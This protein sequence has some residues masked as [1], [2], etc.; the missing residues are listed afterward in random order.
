MEI[1]VWIK[2]AFGQRQ[3]K[4]PKIESL[5]FKNPLNTTNNRRNN[6]ILCK[7]E[8]RHL[9][10]WNTADCWVVFT[11]NLTSV[12]QVLM[13]AGILKY[14]NLPWMKPYNW[15]VIEKWLL[16][17]YKN[18]NQEQIKLKT[19]LTKKQIIYINKINKTI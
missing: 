9:V 17:K 8:F 1:F 12:R 13:S 16:A 2:K 4:N 11:N 14:R 7:A 15:Y 3:K 18:T 6:N 10:R 19:S 5:L